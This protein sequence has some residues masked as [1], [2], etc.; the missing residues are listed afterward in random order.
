M[1]QGSVSNQQP[2]VMSDH[3]NR[4]GLNQYTW[5]AYGAL[6]DFNR[7]SI[8]DLVTAWKE[9]EVN[10]PNIAETNQNTHIKGILRGNSTT[11]SI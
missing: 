1:E 8:R 5:S 4:F 3:P 6:Q 9:V 10:E 2:D 7:P 11:K